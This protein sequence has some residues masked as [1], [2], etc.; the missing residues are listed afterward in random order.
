[1]APQVDHLRHFATTLANRAA[2]FV[3]DQT[4]Q[5]EDE[6]RSD[7]HPHGSRAAITSIPESAEYLIRDHIAASRPHDHIVGEELGG[8]LHDTTDVTWLLDPV[9]GT[10]NM[11]HGSP[12]YAC[13]I[14]AVVGGTVLAAAVAEPRTGRIWAAG[15]GEGAHLLDPSVSTRWRELRVSAPRELDRCLLATGFSY[16]PIERAEQGAVLACLLSDVHDVRRSGS[17]A[18]DLCHVAAGWLDGF[19]EHGLHVWDWAAGLL[20]AEEAGAFIHEPGSA[21]VGRRIGQP[22]LAAS[23]A[24]AAPL[25]EALDNA[26]AS[27]LCSANPRV[28][29]QM[30]R[31]STP[32][33]RNLKVR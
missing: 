33:P 22:V 4:S 2:E 19:Y 9:A 24:I 8:E 32:A 15:L 31:Q 28:L 25:V 23:P 10:V 27:R 29:H 16:D 20:I 21:G 12:Q 17:A 6:F 18:L 7:E 30:P 5:N 3:R 11:S 14:A 1:M 13:S 26:G